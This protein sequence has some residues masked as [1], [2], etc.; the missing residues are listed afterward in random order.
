MRMIP[1]RPVLGGLLAFAGLS[2]LAG[3]NPRS[4]HTGFEHQNLNLEDSQVDWIPHTFFR[5]PNSGPSFT[6]YPP[7]N[8]VTEDHDLARVHNPVPVTASHIHGPTNTIGFGQA[9]RPVDQAPRQ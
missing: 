1:L 6:A 8:L 7:S 9:F 2:L 3:C 4:N 5:N